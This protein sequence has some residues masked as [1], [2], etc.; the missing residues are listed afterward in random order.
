MF[1]AIGMLFA[2]PWFDRG[3]VKSVRFRSSAHFWNLTQFAICFIALGVLGTMPASDTA[4]LVG[5]IATF[6]YFGFFGFLWLY[7]K[8]EKTKPVPERMTK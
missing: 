7:S 1:A 8:N 5:R 6:G 4:N 2:L 3:I